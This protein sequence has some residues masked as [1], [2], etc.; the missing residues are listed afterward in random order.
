MSDPY[1][2]VPEDWMVDVRRLVGVAEIAA[3]F[4]VGRTTVTQ[5]AAR[6]HRNGFPRPVHRLASGPMW[7]VDDVVRWYAG[8]VPDKGG[9]PGRAPGAGQLEGFGR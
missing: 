1:A 5:W 4:L 6:R 2:P 9:R 7:D 3:L 8:Y